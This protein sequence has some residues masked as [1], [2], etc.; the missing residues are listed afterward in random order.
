MQ[1]FCAA[2]IPRF[3]VT[4]TFDTE[5][6]SILHSSVLFLALSQDK[7]FFQ[8]RKKVSDISEESPPPEFLNITIV[9]E[10]TSG[11]GNITVQMADKTEVEINLLLSN[12]SFRIPAGMGY[13]R[14]NM[15]QKRY[16]IAFY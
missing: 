4:C 15:P 9:T 7:A 11:N 13:F 12:P 1:I 14:V 8:R 6:I 2:F 10:A 16:K 5:L 3:F